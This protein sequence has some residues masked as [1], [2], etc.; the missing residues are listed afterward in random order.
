MTSLNEI[1][2]PVVEVDYKLIDSGN[3]KKLEQFGKWVIVRP[4]ST[5]IWKPAKSELWKQA[6]AEFVRSG[7]ETGVWRSSSA[8]PLPKN[9]VINHDGLKY[10][11]E[12]NQFGNM[13]LFPE[14]WTYQKW[15]NNVVQNLQKKDPKETLKILNLF[16]Y[17]G[18]NSLK[19]V[20]MGCQVTNVDSSKQS[21]SLLTKNLEINGFAG[22]TRLI[23]EDVKKFLNREIKRGAKYDGILLDPPTFGRGPQGEIFKIET[24]LSELLQLC[25]QLLIPERSFIILTCHTH[26]L[27]PSTLENLFISLFRQR[28]ETAEIV[29]SDL[30]GR[31]LPAGMIA[32]LSLDKPKK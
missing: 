9:W 10:N 27:L 12:P 24:D 20:K 1:D 4:I 2:T 8:K 3:G 13:A 26:G 22:K 7:K 14:H 29:L 21:M 28:P 5:A 16:S 19:L 18:S 17:S 31:N 23:L 15:L 6:H 25:Q 11:L 30:G 32:K